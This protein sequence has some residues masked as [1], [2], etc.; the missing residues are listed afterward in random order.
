MKEIDMGPLS[1]D[2]SIFEKFELDRPPVGVKFL[3]HK[4][5]GVEAW[6]G[7]LGFCEMFAQAQDVDHPFYCTKENENC[8]GKMPLGWTDMAPWAE[9]GQIGKEFE[10][11][12]EEGR[13]N[14]RLYDEF[15]R[16]N[17]GVINYVVLARLD[18]LNFEPDVFIVPAKPSQAEIIMR[19]MSYSTGE[20][21][22]PRSTCVL[23]CSWLYVYPFLTGKVNMLVSGMHFGMKAREVYPEGYLLLSIPY[24]WIPTITANLKKM[25]WVIPAYAAGREG[26]LEMEEKAYEKLASEG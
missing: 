11:F 5:A 20:V 3:H 7:K 8:S 14:M 2:L 26:W 15:K 22:Q 19:A 25:K 6:D 13:P 23:G 18:C 21:W 24:N 10:L 16:F 12:E 9:A 1:Q 17:P 4:P